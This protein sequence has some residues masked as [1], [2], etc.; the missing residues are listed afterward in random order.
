MERKASPASEGLGRIHQAIDHE[1]AKKA[2]L[3]SP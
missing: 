2:F 1:Q 3:A